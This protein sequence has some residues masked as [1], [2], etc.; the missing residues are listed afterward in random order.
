MNRPYRCWYRVRQPQLHEE[1]TSTTSTHSTTFAPAR[2]T[3]QTGKAQVSSFP[4]PPHLFSTP[5]PRTLYLAPFH[6]HP[7]PSLGTPHILH[8]FSE[9]GWKS[10]GLQNCFAPS[11][12]LKYD[13]IICISAATY[14]LVGADLDSPSLSLSLLPTISKYRTLVTDILRPSFTLSRSRSDCRPGLI[15]T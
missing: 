10:P 8:V 7:R 4:T 6:F 14:P 9:F 5:P 3:P 15:P 13:E 11:H 2:L 1:G 12:S